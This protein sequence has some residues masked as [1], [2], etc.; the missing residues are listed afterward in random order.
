MVFVDALTYVY[1]EF[2]IAEKVSNNEVKAAPIPKGLNK[3]TPIQL[4]RL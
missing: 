1:I 3:A 4:I 2:K